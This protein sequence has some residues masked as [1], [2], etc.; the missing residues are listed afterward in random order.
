MSEWKP[1]KDISVFEFDSEKW[2]NDGPRYL[3]WAG[4][5]ITIGS[6]GYTKKG[7]GRWRNSLGN[8]NPTHFMPLPAPPED[9]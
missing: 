2:Y 7:K 6:Y 4:H 8:I 9:K 5:H 3:L 1:I